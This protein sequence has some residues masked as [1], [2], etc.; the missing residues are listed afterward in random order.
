MVFIYF[1]GLPNQLIV[2]NMN[3]YLSNIY[4]SGTVSMWNNSNRFGILNTFLSN[5]YTI[6]WD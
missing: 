5:G 2:I 3:L 1:F 6:K 4:D